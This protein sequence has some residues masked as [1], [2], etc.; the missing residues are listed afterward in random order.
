[1]P[2]TVG[3]ILAGYLRANGFD[4]LSDGDECG[5]RFDDLFPCCGPQDRCFPAKVAKGE[6]GETMMVIPE[7]DE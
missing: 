5:C 2:K 3:D 4:G 1:M 6:D 7:N